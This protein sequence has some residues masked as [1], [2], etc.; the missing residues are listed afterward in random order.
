M[1]WKWKKCEH[2]KS[3]IVELWNCG[4]WNSGILES[5]K[6]IIPPVQRDAK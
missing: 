3:V 6:E 2:I 4:I 1:I 5:E